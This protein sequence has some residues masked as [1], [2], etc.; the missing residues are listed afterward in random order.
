MSVVPGESPSGSWPPPEFDTGIPHSARMYDYWLGGKDNFA[1]DRSM[2]DAFLREIPTLRDMAKENR[3]FVNRAT[4]Y[5]AAEGVH[6]FL[7]IGTGIPTSPNLH[8]TAQAVTPDARVVYV[9][10]DPVVLAHARALMVSTDEGMTTFLDADV[11]D[12]ESILQQ[13]EFRRVIDLGRPVALM[14]IAVLM[15]VGEEDEPYEIM[16]VFRD[17]LPPGSYLALTHPTQD[18]DPQAVETVTAFATQGGM[19]FVPRTK[20]AVAGFFGDWDLVGPG[21]VPV[22]EW[23]PK[24]PPA[25]PWSAYYWS[26][27]ARKP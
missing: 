5:L 4:R 12:P 11:R 25:N 27:V 6:Q 16:K 21:I 8:E 1:V 14:V 24:T 20:D 3:K 18:F 23:F 9:D 17:A 26:G 22:R 2:G 19:T 7:D 15:L 13:P 10:N